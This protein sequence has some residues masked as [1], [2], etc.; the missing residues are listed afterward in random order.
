[1]MCDVAEDGMLFLLQ[2][3]PESRRWLNVRGAPE[4]PDA[5][6]RD[7]I[8]PLEV[9]AFLVQSKGHFTTKHVTSSSAG[10]AVEA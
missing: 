8:K 5:V 7:R 6:P 4:V 3:E 9:H 10:A 1:M 2:C